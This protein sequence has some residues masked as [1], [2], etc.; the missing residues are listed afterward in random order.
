MMVRLVRLT[1]S[2]AAFADSTTWSIGFARTSSAT[3]A[4]DA[5]AAAVLASPVGFAGGVAHS[6]RSCSPMLS[7]TETV[8]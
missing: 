3:A 7:A 5:G 1:F 4:A 2:A 8:E 6:A